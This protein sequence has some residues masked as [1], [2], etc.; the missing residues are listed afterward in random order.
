MKQDMT[1]IE[2]VKEVR[3]GKRVFSSVVTNGEHEE[4]VIVCGCPFLKI[5]RSPGATSSNYIFKCPT[6]DDIISNT[7]FVLE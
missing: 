6:A 4:L 1:Y 3:N 5:P 2:A 7:W